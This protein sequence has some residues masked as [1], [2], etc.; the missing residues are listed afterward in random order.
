MKFK[1]AAW[2]RFHHEY[3]VALREKHDLHHK[4]STSRIQVGVVVII[5]GEGKNQGKRKL[6]IEENLQVGKDEVVRGKRIEHP[7]QL[8]YP[9]E[10]HCCT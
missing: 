8:S 3:L 9:L 1:E 4:E 10:L 7:I 5:K 2:K 6:E